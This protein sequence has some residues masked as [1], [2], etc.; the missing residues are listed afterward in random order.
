KVLDPAAEALITANIKAT[1]IEI[2]LDTVLAGEEIVINGLTFTAHGTVTDTTLRQFSISGDNSADAA[3]LAI[4][5]ND[6]T[7]GVPGVLATAA[8]AV[9]TLTSTIPGATLLTVTSTDA[10]FT[11]STTEAQCY[12][13]LESLALDA[14]FT[15]IAAKVTTTAASNVAV[16][17]LRYHSRKKITQKM[18]AQYPA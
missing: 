12:V 4:C 17:L 14:E 8:V 10:T 9:I 16:M 13:D 7:D 11:I 1:E 6:P 18:G 2:S 15:H 3:E 5:I